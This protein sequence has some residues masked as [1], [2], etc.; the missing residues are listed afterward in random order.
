MAFFEHD[1]EIGLR[2]I[3]NPNFLSN[4]SILAFLENI[5][6]Y[7]SDSINFGLNNRLRKYRIYGY[8]N[9]PRGI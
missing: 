6:S 5:G 8:R 1:F 3:E 7:H 4:K 9:R 2:D